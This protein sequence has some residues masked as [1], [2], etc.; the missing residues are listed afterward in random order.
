MSTNGTK[1]TYTLLL[2]AGTIAGWLAA[3]LADDTKQE[4]VA[5]RTTNGQQNE[6]IARLEEQM[7]YLR[8]DL[9]EIKEGQRLILQ[10]VRQ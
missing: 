3:G 5:Q 2:A 7:T 6:K 8:A 1:T 9:N 10:A 4:L